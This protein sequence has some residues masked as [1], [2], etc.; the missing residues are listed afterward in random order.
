MVIKDNQK[1][2]YFSSRLLEKSKSKFEFKNNSAKIVKKL[3]EQSAGITT[4]SF[5]PNVAIFFFVFHRKQDFST[6]L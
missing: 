5:V 3:F 6:G 4:K 2:I 1:G